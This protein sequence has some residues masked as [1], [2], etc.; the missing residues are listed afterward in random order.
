MEEGIFVILKTRVVLNAQ[1][2]E[3]NTKVNKGYAA[4][5]KETV[6]IEENSDYD[7]IALDSKANDS[8]E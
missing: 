4:L 1:V 3:G 7:K 8:R 6:N 2:A 5:A